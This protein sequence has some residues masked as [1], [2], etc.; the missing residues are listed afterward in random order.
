M[1]IVQVTNKEP[2]VFTHESKT[3]KSKY[4]EHPECNRLADYRCKVCGKLSCSEHQYFCGCEA[5]CD[6][7]GRDF[8]QNPS[9]SQRLPL[10]RCDCGSWFCHLCAK[11]VRE[12]WEEPTGEYTYGGT[13]Y[14]TRTKIRVICEDCCNRL[15]N[16]L[17][18]GQHKRWQHEQQVLQ[19]R[20][21]G[22]CSKCGAKLGFLKIIGIE[23]CW[24]H[25]MSM[26]LPIPDLS[27]KYTFLD[28]E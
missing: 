21:T 19:W 5:I 9:P 27:T 14:T 24:R 15:R 11:K 2:V 10:E 6:T 1:K 18:Q 20:K 7:C 28:D 4:C 12:T 16:R 25:S 3:D 22:R 23:H 13:K 17:R 26:D 8:R